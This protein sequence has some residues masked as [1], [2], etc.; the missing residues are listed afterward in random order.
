MPRATAILDFWF[1]TLDAA[2][3]PA[4]EVERRWFDVDARVDAE[5]R[6]RFEADLRSAAAG[7]LVRW[8][9]E[10]RGALALVILFDQFP[11]NMYRGTPRAFLFDEH[12]RA[13]AAR[14]VGNGHEAALWPVERAFLY[15]PFEHAESA[16]DQA[17]AV[18]RFSGLVEAA[19]EEQR[20]RFREFLHHAERHREVIERFGRFPHRNAVLGRESTPEEQ[21]FLDG[22]AD[23]WGQGGATPANDVNRE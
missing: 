12:A 6:A 22:G 10:A 8:E 5:I 13:V 11:R 19:P 17:E 3:V 21:A 7:R 23:A 16:D 14:A 4:P 2:G 9:Q 1:G 18:R 20:P 15:L